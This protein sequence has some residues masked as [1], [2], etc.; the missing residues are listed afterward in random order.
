M[1]HAREQR[2]FTSRSCRDRSPARS[3]RSSRAPKSL[4]FQRLRSNSA[5]RYEL[6]RRLARARRTS[7]ARLTSIEVRGLCGVHTAREARAFAIFKKVPLLSARVRKFPTLR[8]FLLARPAF[9]HFRTLFLSELLSR[10]VGSKTQILRDRARTN[11][12]AE[13]PVRRWCAD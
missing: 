12:C 5:D 4:F 8:A 10:A 1:S 2:F 9:E 11:R 6:V 3:A 13:W 7:V